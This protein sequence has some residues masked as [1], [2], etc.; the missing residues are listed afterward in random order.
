MKA[1]N[2][3]LRQGAPRTLAALKQQRRK[4]QRA[5]ERQ[6]FRRETLAGYFT[7]L[8]LDQAEARAI[9]KAAAQRVGRLQSR[10]LRDLRQLLDRL[11][12]AAQAQ[13]DMVADLSSVADRV[14][15]EIPVRVVRKTGEQ[16]VVSR[17]SCAV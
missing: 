3:P 1:I 12:H 9:A 17:A 13:L 2:C 15:I 6:L 8:D 11:D 10:A 14:L 4:Q 16:T 5:A 7:E